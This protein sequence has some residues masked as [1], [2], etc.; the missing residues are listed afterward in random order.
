MPFSKAV[1]LSRLIS[2]LTGRVPA[3]WNRLA[4]LILFFAVVLTSLPVHIR[5]DGANAQSSR[6]RRIKGAP[7][8]NLPNLEESRSIQPGTARIMSPVPATKC[9]GRDEKCKRARGKVQ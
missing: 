4:F 9:R 7:G 5:H 1:P 2:L 3:K 8:L 6:P